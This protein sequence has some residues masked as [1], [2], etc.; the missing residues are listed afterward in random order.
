MKNQKK[1]FLVIGV[2]GIIGSGKSTVS[3]F[4]KEKGARV[5]NT[6][7]RARQLMET[8]ES[9]REKIKSNFGKES[10]TSDGKLNAKKIASLVF[11]N[12]DALNRLNLIVHPEVI[13]SVREEI[14]K[15]AKS[16]FRGILV[17]DAPLIFE[18][19]LSGVMDETVVVA[20]P[21]DVCVQRVIERSGFS[22]E[23]VLSRM[24][25]QW[26]LEK[27][28]ALAD[29]VIWNDGSIDQLKEQAEKIYSDWQK[30]LQ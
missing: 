15:L 4:F 16:D 21:E 7:L 13:R 14:R 9:L 24:R 20:A 1:P 6:D 22:S 11:Q 17:I 10:Y 29:R 30:K 8:S 27:K 2:T 25:N 23:E 18:T 19:G 12:P 26:P 5:I 3:Q 28:I